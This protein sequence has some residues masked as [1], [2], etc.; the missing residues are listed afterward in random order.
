MFDHHEWY[1]FDQLL[2]LANYKHSH[3]AGAVFSLSSLYLFLSIIYYIIHLDLEFMDQSIFWFLEDIIDVNVNDMIETN[4][5]NLA[6]IFNISNLATRPITFGL[7]CW[8]LL[9]CLFTLDYKAAGGVDILFSDAF[10]S[11]PLLEHRFRRRLLGIQLF[12]EALYK[13]AF[14]ISRKL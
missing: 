6:K 13:L 2:S 8:R 11:L 3:Q 1:A 4:S 9:K 14:I 7:N 5:N 10:R 12:Y